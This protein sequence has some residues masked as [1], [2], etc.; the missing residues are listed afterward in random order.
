MLGVDQIE[1]YQNELVR[2]EDEIHFENREKER[3]MLIE[4]R[5]EIISILENDKED[6]KFY[7]NY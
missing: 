5:N 1:D 4:R 6:R 7:F 3:E 2:L